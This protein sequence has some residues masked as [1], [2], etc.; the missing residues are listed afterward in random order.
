MS[1]TTNWSL[2]RP[3]TAVEQEL[4]QNLLGKEVGVEA[5]LVSLNESDKKFTEYIFMYNHPVQNVASLVSFYA[6]VKNKEETVVEFATAQL[7]TTMATSRL[8]EPTNVEELALT[9]AK[10]MGVKL[11]SNF[12]TD[13]KYYKEKSQHEYQF[14][15]WKGNEIITKASFCR[16]LTHKNRSRFY[17]LTSWHNIKSDADNYELYKSDD[18]KVSLGLNTGET[19]KICNID[20]AILNVDTNSPGWNDCLNNE[21][22][23]KLSS[24]IPLSALGYHQL[25]L[26]QPVLPEGG[27]GGCVFINDLLCGVYLGPYENAPIDAILTTLN[28]NNSNPFILA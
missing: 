18:K 22:K 19:A 7:T 11:I 8:V 14:Q 10:K 1:T 20:A 6:K 5:L 16:I 21:F 23:P 25:N 17:I 28:I 15:A 2:Y 3:L 27:S 4:F 24:L 9:V 13:D 26:V 12:D